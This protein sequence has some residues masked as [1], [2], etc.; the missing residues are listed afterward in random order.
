[1]ISAG[2]G[3]TAQHAH[4]LALKRLFVADFG[5]GGAAEARVDRHGLIILSG[6]I[7]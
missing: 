3:Q 6:W 5:L 2:F 4:P 1:M 7:F